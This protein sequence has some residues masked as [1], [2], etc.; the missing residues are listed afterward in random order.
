MSTPES[1][2]DYLKDLNFLEAPL[3]GLC[4]KPLNELSEAE[5]RNFVQDQRALRES[6]QTF[7][8]RV[9]S[10]EDTTTTAKPKENLFADFYEEEKDG[11]TTT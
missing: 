5:L 2:E 11:K 6:R 1:L 7:K 3:V 9:A 4:K 10:S 8:A